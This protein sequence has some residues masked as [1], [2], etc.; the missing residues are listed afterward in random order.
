MLGVVRVRG[1]SVRVISVRVV[2]VGVETGHGDGR[3]SPALTP[4]TYYP[5]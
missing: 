4:N 1:L 5:N 3:W 2:S